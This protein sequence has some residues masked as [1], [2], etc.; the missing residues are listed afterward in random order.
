[1]NSEPS[2]MTNADWFNPFDLSYIHDPLAAASRLQATT[3][4]FFFK[5]LAL[6]MVSKYE[7]VKTVLKDSDTF[8]NKAMGIIPPPA[9]LAPLVH[10][11][12]DHELLPSMDRPEHPALRQPLASTFTPRAVMEKEEVI[13]AKANALIDAFIDDGKCNLMTQFS[14]PL[15]L[16]TIVSALGL[17]AEDSDLFRQW[18]DDFMTMLSLRRPPE[19]EP[20]AVHPMPA[21]EVREHWTRLLDANR[22]FIDYVA[23]LR[24]EPQGDI[25]SVLLA[26][27]D[28]DGNHQ[29]SD[30]TAIFN[31]PT[32]VA[33]GHDTT[34]NLVGQAII[35]LCSN[36]EQRDIVQND[37]A[38][39]PQAIEEALRMRASALGV[40]RLVKENTTIRGVDIPAGAFV[41][42]ML[43]AAGLD[44]DQF[45]DP[46]TFDLD[47]VNSTQ[48]LS[49]GFGRHN[50]IGNQLARL[51]ARVAIGELLRRIPD[52]RL[53]T[54]EPV[55]YSAALN[56]RLATSIPLEWGK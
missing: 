52:L 2:E 53:S 27:K 39:L 6:W 40:L 45:A 51:Q 50:C 34:A 23:K 1:M 42:A 16:S 22:Y 28:P 12:A 7:D 37:M 13:R 9:D 38:R 24:S 8:S 54:T 30:G 47:R 26:L 14:Y 36:P 35:L 3:P 19:E 44:S 43:N 56:A 48:H 20:E 46:G 17:P 29:V 33:A 15:T 31:I 5:P 32:L 11:F 25:L 10:N 49:F 41:Y 4:V 21:E 55:T 18:S